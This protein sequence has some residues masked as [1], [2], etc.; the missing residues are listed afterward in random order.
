M[1]FAF[2][3]LACPKWDFATIA[4]K[5]REYGYDGVE[6]RAFLNENILTTANVFL[7]DP[8]KVRDI[9]DR[10]GVAVACLSTSVS[11]TGDQGRDHR[12]AADLR[13][14]I[15]VAAGLGAMFVKVFDVQLRP[16][17]NREAAAA[18]MGNWLRPQA[19]YAAEK[20]LKI[21]VENQL[22]FRR[23]RELWMIMETAAHPAIAACWDVLNAALVGEGP[24]VSIPTLNSR[25]ELVQV[26]DAYV[27]DVGANYC[28]LGD[29]DLRV[30]E[31]VNRLKGIGYDGW[32]SF[33]YEKAWLVNLAEPEESLPQALAVLKDMCGIETAA[34][35]AEV[36]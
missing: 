7:T 4:A 29:G 32:I 17:Q 26:K 33:E 36:E 16:G 25:I 12:A 1:K 27:R 28:K 9:F 11:M 23:A 30:P 3:T 22:S 35:A 20:N 5:A 14:S 31:L 18:V 19:D 6:I 21:L 24:A 34:A 8:A 2:S 13:Q 15:D 10:A